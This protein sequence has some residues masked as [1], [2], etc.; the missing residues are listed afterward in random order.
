MGFVLVTPTA[1]AQPT[2]KSTP[3]VTPA[4]DPPDMPFRRA[5]MGLSSR[6]IVLSL[7]TNLHLA[8][9]PALL[10]THTV[11]EGEPLNLYGPP[12]N[13]TATKFVCDFRGKRL[14]GN[15][16]MFSWSLAAPLAT[17]SQASAMTG[18]F[19]GLNDKNG[20]VTFNYDVVTDQGHFARIH[21]SPRLA[22]ESGVVTIVRRFEVGPCPRDLWL[23]AHAEP[24]IR[25]R[26]AF[27]EFHSTGAGVIARP[28]DWLLMKFRSN[29]KMEWQ[30]RQWESGYRVL[31]YSEKDGKGP[32]S[33]VRTNFL[34]VKALEVFVK[35]PAH[36]VSVDFEICSAIIQTT[37]EAIQVFEKWKNLPLERRR[38]GPSKSD[39]KQALSSQPKVHL[40]EADFA[41]KP[42]G[43]E[44]FTV[45]HFPVP[46]GINLLVGG[47][48]FMP[49]GDLA[50]CTY[51]GEVWIVEGA[52]GAPGQTRWRRFARG[53]NEP[54]GLRV[55]NGHIHVT[56]K[57]ELTRLV[58]T[59]G[60]GEADLFECIS[61]DWGYT[62][63]YHSFATGPAL[64]AAGNFYVMIT[65]HRTIYDV[66]FMGW[67]LKVSRNAERG[68]RSVGPAV[69]DRWSTEAFCSGLR[70]PNGF[71]EFNGDIFM[72]DNQGHWIA[73]NKLNHLQSG[74]FYGHPSAKPAPL[75]QFNG[76]TNFA[77]PA[78]WFPY[79]WVRSASG[80]GTIA[81]ERF[82]PFKGQ[83]LVGEFQNAS[84]VRV[85]LE[86]VN[87]QWQ[88]AVFPFTKGFNSGVNRLAFGHDG[89]LYVGGL[90]MGHWTSIAPQPHSLDRVS[91]TGRVPFEIKEVH[92]RTDGFELT[93][94]QAVDPKT[95]G[96]PESYDAAQYTYAY[97]GRHNAPEKDR[98]EKIPGPPVLLVKAEVSADR[99][100]VRLTLEGALTNHVIM[101]RALDVKDTGG[102]KLRNDTFHY[103]MNQLPK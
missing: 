14:W 58:D 25:D 36:N 71:G 21:E 102:R 1:S 80:I 89:R 32:Y 22:V 31:I 6:S 37:N 20:V 96:N 98:E 74:R 83:M 67:C 72:T 16:P 62:G 57:C 55:V 39:A 59:D 4:H 84:V 69:F 7:A 94:T 91:F 17:N 92:A 26:R 30:S 75:E 97:D 24:V 64:D 99:L 43:D 90:R 56:Q 76:D 10:R 40:P 63:N 82:G 68:T 100:T 61:Q 5:P 70:V 27:G 86:K 45:E 87:G 52:T 47:M 34:A 23:L 101:V 42:T 66:P 93:F 81:D 11:W 46:K 2:T 54:G 18:R 44:S 65:G 8:W 50:I 28:N 41:E 60:N 103:T 95:A 12:F 53:L 73:A 77:P 88:G 35:V 29:E 85:A 38:L 49:N 78:V 3:A 33:V 13:G 19:L 48:D 79:A 51:A 15:P 9:D